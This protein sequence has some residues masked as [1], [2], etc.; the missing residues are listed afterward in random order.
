M[1]RTSTIR[2]DFYISWKMLKDNYKAFLATEIFAFLTYISAVILSLIVIVIIYLIIPSENF[3]G[4]RILIIRGK[5]S[6]NIL[7]VFVMVT[8]ST[9]LTGLLYCQYGLAYDIMSSGDMFTRFVSSFHYFK[10]FWWQYLL[11]ALANSVNLLIFVF[12]EIIDIANPGYKILA[13]TGIMLAQYG[14]MFLFLLIFNCILPSLTAQGKLKNSFVEVYR[15]LKKNFKRL[16]K[17]WLVYFVV[18]ILPIAVT[19]L[20]VLELEYFYW[21]Q[22]WGKIIVAL[23]FCLRLL[24]S[25]IFFFIGFPIKSLIATRIYNSADFERFNPLTSEGPTSQNIFEAKENRTK[26]I[27]SQN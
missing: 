1:K 20:I 21:E 3:E 15:I 14:I 5:I 7:S 10:R 24:F 19:S 23:L 4:I 22:T 6:T 12:S 27:N 11:L 9:L 26:E 25:F 13:D 2:D 17:T 16:V 18:F 8:S